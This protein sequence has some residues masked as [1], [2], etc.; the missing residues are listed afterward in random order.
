MDFGQGTEQT[1]FFRF[2]HL[3]LKQCHCLLQD[4]T[5]LKYQSI[6]TP[7]QC[8]HNKI[9]EGKNGHLQFDRD[10][11]MTCSPLLGDAEILK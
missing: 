10:Y 3:W 7:K 8:K 2:G 5:V 11:L 1:W 6:P 9:I 4:N